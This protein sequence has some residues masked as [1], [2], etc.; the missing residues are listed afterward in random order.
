MLPST[1][2]LLA[3]GI[4]GPILFIAV[5]VFEGATRPDYDPMR[6]PVSLLSLGDSGG[7]Q[8][9]CFVVTGALLVGFSMGVRQAISAGRGSTGVPMALAL[10][11]TGLIVAG[12]F[13]PD[14]SFGYPSGAPSGV[15]PSPSASAYL[16]LVGALLFF[17]GMIA[18]AWLFAARCRADGRGGWAAASVL[19]GAVVLLFLGLSSGG[20][21][22]QPLLPHVTGL[23]Q[24]MSIVFGLAWIAAVAWGLLFGRLVP[25]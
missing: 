1:K 20:P 11:G 2:A 16:H 25:E 5:F 17:I 3:G 7:L 23:F 21:D 19:A 22:G 14:P 8:R 12:V 9:L 10:V 4:V 18:A 13:P 24:R 6:V 15:G